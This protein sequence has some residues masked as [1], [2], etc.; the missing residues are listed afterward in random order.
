M[1]T[2]L[3]FRHV[4]IFLLLHYDVLFVLRSILLAVYTMKKEQDIMDEKR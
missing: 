4:I 3:L 1:I 2:Y